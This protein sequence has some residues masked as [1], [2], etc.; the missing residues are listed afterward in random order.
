MLQIAKEI[1][2]G[3]SPFLL[4]YTTASG[5][6]GVVGYGQEEGTWIFDGK[7]YD[8]RILIWDS[9][10]HT[11]LREDACL[12][13]DSQTFDY[14][15]PYY[16]VHVTDGASD[17]VG[18]IQLVCNDISV[19]NAYPYPFFVEYE[20]GDLNCDGQITVADA[21]LLSR[22]VTEDLTE[23]VM[24]IPTASV[25]SSD[26]DSDGLLTVNDVSLLLQK[27]QQDL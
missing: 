4:V 12:Y 3:A 14:C 15:I 25:A 9:N 27:M 16:G 11:A 23:D 18:G 5:T 21:I 10:F 6:H 7:T 1:P 22:L 2:N 8:G 17:N 19:L 20:E 26:F 13:Y 24:T